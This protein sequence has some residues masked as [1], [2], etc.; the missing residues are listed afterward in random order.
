MTEI[1][2]TVESAEAAHRRAQAE[3]DKNNEAFRFG[4]PPSLPKW[5]PAPPTRREKPADVQLEVL[6]LNKAKDRVRFIDMP[7]P[8]YA[9]D[10]NYVA[11]LRIDILKTLNPAKFPPFKHIEMRAFLAHRNGR[12]VGRMTAQYDK[13]YNDYHET[14]AGWVGYFESIDDPD[15]AHALFDDG[16]AWLKDQ[17][18]VEVFGPANPTMNYQSGLL[19]ENFERPAVIETLYNPRYYEALF[20]SYGFGKAKDLYAWWMDVSNGMD[21]PKRKRIL[22]IAERIKKREGITIRNASVKH[23]DREIELIHELFTAGWQK[24]WGF[25]PVPKAEFIELAQDLKKIVVEELLMFV[26]VDDR[27]VGFA[28]TVPDI[29]EKLPANGRLLPFGWV[30]LLFGLKKTKHARLFLLGMLPEYRKRGLESIMIAETA[31]RAQRLGYTSGEVSWTLEDNDLVNRAIES[32][33]GY[34]DRRWRMF[35]LDLTD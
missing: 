29:N 10:P 13:I 32:M 33:E 14:T 25:A 30:N 34:I 4:R 16:I 9:G 12:P 28:L 26:M 31:L 5:K 3:G 21:S 22:R 24:N 20:N 19:I 6:D 11:P 8:I 2:K 18:M 1:E 17:G 35:G 27:P 23:A 15:V 7:A